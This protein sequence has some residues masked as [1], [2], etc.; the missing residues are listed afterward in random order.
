[1]VK[2]PDCYVYFKLQ[3]V[4]EGVKYQSVKDSVGNNLAVWS[5]TKS[6]TVIPVCNPEQE[7][8]WGCHI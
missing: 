8:F 3:E 5:A 2:R 4:P 7:E 6:R 1:M